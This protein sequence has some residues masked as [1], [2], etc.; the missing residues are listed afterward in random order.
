M[1][2]KRKCMMKNRV[3][4]IFH[5]MLKSSPTKEGYDESAVEH[6]FRHERKAPPERR[7]CKWDKVDQEKG[8]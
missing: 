4:F 7:V 8:C 5:Q 2:N 3:H 1:N 6:A